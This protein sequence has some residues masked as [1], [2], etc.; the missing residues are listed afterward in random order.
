MNVLNIIFEIA[1]VAV[2]EVVDVAVEEEEGEEIEEVVALEDHLLVSSVTR[3]GICPVVI[4][5]ILS[6]LLPEI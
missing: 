4:Y 1:E 6:N 2:E 3:R 5:Y